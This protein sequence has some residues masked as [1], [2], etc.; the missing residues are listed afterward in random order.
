MNKES[1]QEQEGVIRGA[2]PPW[3]E[4]LWPEGQHP[5]LHKHLLNCNQLP[6]TAE[7][8]ESTQRSFQQRETV[9]R[10]LRSHR[11]Y[12]DSSG[13]LWVGG[14]CI[15]YCLFSLQVCRVEDA[16][17]RYS[18]LW[19]LQYTFRHITRAQFSPNKGSKINKASLLVPGLSTRSCSSPASQCPGCLGHH[20]APTRLPNTHSTLSLHRARFYIRPIFFF[21]IGKDSYFV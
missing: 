18:G 7:H 15:Y 4:P 12:L 19:K 16:L 9:Y 10:R 17:T 2:W 14:V 1:K 11:N 3:L 6:K 5:K 13:I 8:I 20:L 21:K